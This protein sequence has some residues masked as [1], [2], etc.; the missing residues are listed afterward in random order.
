MDC[1]HY[2]YVKHQA[3]LPHSTQCTYN[4]TNG[5]LMHNITLLF[6]KSFPKIYLWMLYSM[7]DLKQ[8]DAFP[9]WNGSSF[10]W[11]WLWNI[12]NT[13]TRGVKL[14]HS[15]V[16]CV[17]FVVVGKSPSTMGNVY[18][19]DGRLYHRDWQTPGI[20]PSWSQRNFAE[21]H[22]QV[23]FGSC[24]IGGKGGLWYLPT[25]GGWGGRW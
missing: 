14:P 22:G 24:Q 23:S 1:N 9:C 7:Y 16:C 13:S 5:N 20:I 8:K 19:V 21:V 10:P 15:V 25:L 12:Q 18:S 11:I 17:I 4:C 2:F 3:T 6:L